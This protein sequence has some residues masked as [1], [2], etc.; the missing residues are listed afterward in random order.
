MILNLMSIIIRYLIYQPGMLLVICPKILSITNKLFSFNVQY[1]QQAGKVI[2]QQQF[3]SD[4]MMLEPA[5]FDLW[6]EAIKELNSQR[7]KQLVL[8]KN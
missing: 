7:K 6:N 3:R 5:N 1:S 8:K 4:V 2:A